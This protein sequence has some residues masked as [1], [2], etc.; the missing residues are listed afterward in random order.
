[1]RAG[2][3]IAKMVL[4]EPNFCKGI[5]VKTDPTNAPNG[6]KPPVKE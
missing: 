2:A 5:K 1:M 4:R 6:P 3:A